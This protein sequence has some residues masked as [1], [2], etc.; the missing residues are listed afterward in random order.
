MATM[1]F[2]SVQYQTSLASYQAFNTLI[3]NAFSAMGWVQ[4]SDTGQG[5]GTA[6]PAAGAY[7]G[8]QI[9]G[10]NDSL[11]ATAPCFA[12]I[13]YGCASENVN[14]PVVLLTVNFGGATDGTGNFVGG[15][16]QS[17]RFAPYTQDSISYTSGV[18]GSTSRIAFQLNRSNGAMHH[19]WGIERSKSNTGADTNEG[20]IV[21]SL[22]YGD[23]PRVRTLLLSPGNN[24]VVAPPC[25]IQYQASVHS[26]QWDGLN[27][28]SLYPVLVYDQN[29]LRNPGMNF[30]LHT[31]FDVPADI[32]YQANV[33]GSS[34]T[35]TT[36]HSR[37]N[38]TAFWL[39]SYLCD[40]YTGA[41]Q[42]ITASM[43]W[44]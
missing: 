38:S 13:Q 11:Q 23:T 9:W 1:S 6:V 4:T 5:V 25:P 36:L 30:L 20:I 2:S 14:R 42:E 44:E 34:H 35:Y 8:Y 16:S 15:A 31:L 43:R 33:Y 27:H 29:G 40:L 17:L 21:Q 39:S 32:T 41:T 37:N 7:N 19:G 12:K 10:M 18:S 24:S 22:N 3:G 26:T 28:A